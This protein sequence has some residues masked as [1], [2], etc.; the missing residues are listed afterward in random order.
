[1]F[2]GLLVVLVVGSILNM[3]V[4]FAYIKSGSMSPT[5]NK[6]DIIF[7]NPLDRNFERGDVIVFKT[8]EEWMCHRI[9]GKTAGG[10][11]TKGD[12]NVVTDQFRS[13][14]P[15]RPSDIVGKVISFDGEVVKIPGAGK[16][17]EF[18]SKTVEK[19][20][21]YV[22][23]LFI[24][25]G[26]LLFSSDSKGRRKKV[27]KYVTIRLRE[28]YA[29]SCIILLVVFTFV[30]VASFEARSIDYGTTVAIGDRPDWVKPGKVFTRELEFRN[31]AAY[32]LFYVVKSLSD[33]ARIDGESVFLLY[34]KENRSITVEIKAP[35]DTSLYSEKFVIY[36]Y[37]PLLP[38]EM[39]AFLSNVHPYLPVLTADILMIGALVTLYFALIKSDEEIRIKRKSIRKIKDLG[40]G[41]L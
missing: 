36:R 17:L 28:V 29:V 21:F 35:E 40:G 38:G 30:S 14:K 16:N 41:I 15:V 9:V 25:G 20:K 18:L 32:P 23:V 3:P 6:Y 24:V 39:T 33:R 31:G 22:L 7:I 4:L 26:L 5:L 12:N 8:G 11:V 37:I 1:M 10:Y 2:G 34:P 27:K 13:R 19:G